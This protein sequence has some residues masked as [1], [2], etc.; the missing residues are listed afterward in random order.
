[1]LLGHVGAAFLARE[2]VAP[3]RFRITAQQRIG[4]R[5]EEQRAQRDAVGAQR[6]ELLRNDRQRHTA[7]HVHRDG[8]ARGLLF[9]L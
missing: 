4:G 9:V 7:A 1:M 3:A 6:F 5:V 2:W 8:H